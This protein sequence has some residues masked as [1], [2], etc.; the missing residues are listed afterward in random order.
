MR[1][2]TIQRL[3][4][5]NRRFYQRW[6][7]SFDDTRRHP[8]PG[9]AHVLEALKRHAPPSLQVLDLGCGNG[10]FGCYLLERWP[11]PVRYRGLDQSAELLA[12]ARE[13]LATWPEVTLRR[14]DVLRWSPEPE[15]RYDLVAV[16]GLLHHLPSFA[17]RARFLRHAG[18][19][20]RPPGLLVA[21]FWQFAHLPRFQRKA[22][23]WCEQ[24]H[25]VAR[26]VDEADLEGGDR[27]LSWGHENPTVRYCH[28][29]NN[30]EVARLLDAAGLTV[31]DRFRSDGAD[32]DLNL[33][34]MARA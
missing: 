33:Y 21:T 20:L 7:Q 22:I 3:S 29:A 4:E 34:V 12:Q 18:R 9:W 19:A 25:W 32:G 6:A 14:V 5:I 28:H 15:E 16:I 2:E 26:V 17:A 24:H 27:L 8:W 30:A 31:C 13:R 10:R 1:P 23:P 11:G